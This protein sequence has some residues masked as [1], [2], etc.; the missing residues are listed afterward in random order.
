MRQQTVHLYLLIL[1]CVGLSLSSPLAVLL[2]TESGESFGRS[3]L[4]KSDE[5][6]DKKIF[7]WMF[8]SHE[9]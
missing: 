8:T 3:I 4:F 7:E 2:T 6:H 1:V 9:L 5:I